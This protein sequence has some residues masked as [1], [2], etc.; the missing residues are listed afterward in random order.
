MT[1]MATG[2]SSGIAAI[3]VFVGAFLLAPQAGY[4]QEIPECDGDEETIITSTGAVITT[5]N[6]DLDDA[7]INKAAVGLAPTIGLHNECRCDYTTEQVPAREF[8]KYGIKN[9]NCS[10]SDR[11]FSEQTRIDAFNKRGKLVIRFQAQARPNDGFEGD[12]DFCLI[13][14]RKGKFRNQSVTIINQTEATNDSCRADIE[15]YDAAN[16]GGICP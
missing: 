16:L 7:L 13:T 2:I 1:R 12:N 8:S 3:V 11:E 10:K 6:W 15:A 5:C 9:L 4:A 14:I